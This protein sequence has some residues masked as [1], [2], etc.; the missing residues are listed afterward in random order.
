[1]S[2]RDAGQVRGHANTEPENRT[3][4][5]YNQA[6]A[7]KAGTGRAALDVAALGYAQLVASDAA[8]TG[9]TTSSIVATAHS[10]IA[11]DVVIFTSGNLNRQMVTVDSVSANA[12]VPG[13]TLSE[14]PA[15]GDG[16]DILRFSIP[17]VD[18]SGRVGVQAPPTLPLPSGAAT[19]ATLAQLDGKVTACDT[20]AVTISAALPAGTNAI[21][22]LA[23]NDGVDIGDVG[24]SGMAAHDAA[25]SG[26]PV[27]AG[28]EARS[29]DGTAVASGDAVRIVA[30]L[31]GRIVVSPHIPIQ[32]QAHFE[33]AHV[34]TT[35]A[36]TIRAAQGA[37]VRQCIAQ[38]VLSNTHASTGSFMTISDGTTGKSF[39]MP[40]NSLTVINFPIAW[41]MA[42][43]A[44]V[45]A[46][47]GT[48]VDRLRVTAFMFNTTI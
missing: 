31:L 20:G 27:L 39:W 11:G 48:S 40:P 19:E 28:A 16:I 4:L 38:L 43:N 24:A 47:A 13:Q 17:R 32:Q 1:M 22:K 2:T 42:D 23:A 36:Q 7:V 29:T 6:T 26:N 37:G 14:A 5:E 34:S 35:V 18:S 25:V 15:N 33:T 45:T 10:A 9:S 8:E 44:A 12:I 41:R 30:D 3:D 21:G 46:T